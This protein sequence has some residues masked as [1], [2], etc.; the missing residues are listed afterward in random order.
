MEKLTLEALKA[1]CRQKGLKI[2]GN[3]PELL[4]RLRARTVAAAAAPKGAPKGGGAPKAASAPTAT[5]QAFTARKV[6]R[7]ALTQAAVPPPEPASEVGKAQAM[8]D[9]IRVDGKLGQLL[10]PV[11]V[12]SLQQLVALGGGSGD[13]GGGGLLMDDFD[14]FGDSEDEEGGGNNPLGGAAYAEAGFGFFPPSFGF[15]G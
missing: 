4:A 14:G 6:P 1:L 10:G 5:P 12:A 15:F 7:T 8:L 9:A 11:V 13:S 2:G 3:K